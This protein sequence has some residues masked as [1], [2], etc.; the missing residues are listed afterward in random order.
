MYKNTRMGGREGGREQ[1]GENGRV[2]RFELGL[3]AK[4]CAACEYRMGEESGGTMISCAERAPC[5]NAPF[6]FRLR[7]AAGLTML[8]PGSGK[9]APLSRRGAGAQR[10]LLGYWGSL[11]SL[12]YEMCSPSLFL[13][14]RTAN[15]IVTATC[16]TAQE[17]HLPSA[18]VMFQWLMDEQRCSAETCRTRAEDDSG[19]S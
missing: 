7:L 9:K 3:S 17:I 13:L 10:R 8:C 2:E 1:T 6:V 18:T 15:A 16:E 12:P 11:F 5:T 4:G 14:R 19:R